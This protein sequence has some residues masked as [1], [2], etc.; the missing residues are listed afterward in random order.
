[1]EIRINETGEVKELNIFDNN[2][3]NWIAD[4]L[5]NYDHLHYNDDLNMHTM[6]EDDFEWWQDY[7]C[8]KTAADKKVAEVLASINRIDR[9]NMIDELSRVSD[10]D[11]ESEPERIM[12]IVQKYDRNNG[13]C[14]CCGTNYVSDDDEIFAQELCDRCHNEINA[15]D[16]IIGWRKGE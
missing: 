8:R 3:I 10:M 12:F 7:I 11:L 1:M 16:D 13:I 5:G 4:L 15:P 6:D 14:K 9:E 2:G